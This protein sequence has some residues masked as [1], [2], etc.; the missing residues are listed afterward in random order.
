MSTSIRGHKGQ[1]QM[2]ENG[3][4]VETFEVTNVQINQD[5]N[6]QRTF[7]VGNPIPEGDQSIEGFSGSCDFE[8][9]NAV[10][11]RF[12]DALINNNLNGIGVSDYSFVVTEEY[13]DGSVS[14][15]AYND[16]QWRYSRNQSGL[17]EKI[18]KRMDF[19]ASSRV[20]IA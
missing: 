4:V 3:R 8:V 20:L 16:V 7:Y 10:I 17:N 1:F 15:Y 5:S 9:K 13:P 6:F 12:I 19:Q 18:T 2:L 14:A 11:E